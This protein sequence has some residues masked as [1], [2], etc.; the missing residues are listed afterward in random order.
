M[1][2]PW[3]RPVETRKFV[4]LGSA[5]PDDIFPA[6]SDNIDTID[7]GCV[8]IIDCPALYIAR[9]TDYKVIVVACLCA[10]FCHQQASPN[11]VHYIMSSARIMSPMYTVQVDFR[12]TSKMVNVLGRR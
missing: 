6:M 4:L 12:S 5:R 7:I 1:Q 9:W 3:S 8:R 10:C 2:R 11:A